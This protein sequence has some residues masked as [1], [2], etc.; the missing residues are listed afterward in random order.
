MIAFLVGIIGFAAHV[1]VTTCWLRLPAR[2][3]PVIRHAFSAITTHAAVIGFWAC[4]VGK[5]DYWPAAAV[6]GF[7]VVIWLFAFSAVYKSVSLRILTTLAQTPAQQM[8]LDEVTHAYVRPEF[9]TRAALLVQLGYAIEQPN[10]YVIT[11]QGKRLARWIRL[12]QRAF[13]IGSSGLYN[14]AIGQLVCRLRGTQPN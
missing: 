10:G 12:I 14:S 7:G 8:P 9:V 13:G 4:C 11:A 2:T 3:A 6:N 1:L 5:F